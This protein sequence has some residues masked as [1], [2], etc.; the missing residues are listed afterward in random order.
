M[1]IDD[2]MTEDYRIRSG[3]KLVSGRAALRK[4]V[5][6]FQSV[7]GDARTEIQEIFADAAG[8]RVVARWANTGVNRGVFG[9]PP[10]GRAVSFT[11]IASWRVS[12]GRL[13]ECWVERAGLEAYLTL[14]GGD[15]RTQAE[16]RRPDDGVGSP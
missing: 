11:G 15:R 2:L 7:Y 6:Q 14:T 9:L 10:D 1:T 13:A 12:G 5:H 8:Q 16:G 3:G 4:R